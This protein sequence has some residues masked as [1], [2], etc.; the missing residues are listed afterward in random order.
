[1][2]LLECQ[3]QLNDD[4]LYVFDS[5]EKSLAYVD[6]NPLDNFHSASLKV[7]KNGQQYSFNAHSSEDM[8]ESLFNL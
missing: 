2:E 1:M 6:N 7:V 5:V 4:S 8:M 3:L